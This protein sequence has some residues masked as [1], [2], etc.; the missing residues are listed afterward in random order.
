MF[1]VLLKRC[2]FGLIYAI[3][4]TTLQ[5]IS[6]IT[7]IA[8]AFKWPWA[9]NNLSRFGEWGDATIKGW[10]GDDQTSA[11]LRFVHFDT[12]FETGAILTILIVVYLI[13]QSIVQGRRQ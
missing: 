3:V 2:G 5:V 6:L 7:V 13:G 10:L 12:T 8:L 11:G 1:R 4:A 9:S